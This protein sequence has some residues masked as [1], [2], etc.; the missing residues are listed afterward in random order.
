ML[1]RFVVFVVL[2]IL[3]MATAACGVAARSAATAEVGASRST[4]FEAWAVGNGTETF[5]RGVGPAGGSG[6][7]SGWPQ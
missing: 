7:R 2:A 5:F 1:H 4:P 6:V 3:A